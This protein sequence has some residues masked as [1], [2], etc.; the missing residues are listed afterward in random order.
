MTFKDTAIDWE[1]LGKT[2]RPQQVEMEEFTDRCFANRSRTALVVAPTGSGKT[3]YCH[4]ISRKYQPALTLVVTNKL[5]DA[6]VER[7][8]DS[9]KAKMHYHCDAFGMD[10]EFA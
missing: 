6:Y 5:M 3:D 8:A 7:G 9:I 2:P 1:R 4:V 10:C